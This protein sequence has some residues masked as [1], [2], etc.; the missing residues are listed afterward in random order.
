MQP[1]AG[2]ICGEEFD[3]TP[4]DDTKEEKAGRTAVGCWSPMKTFFVG[5]ATGGSGG[6]CCRVRVGGGG[7][8]KLV[9]GDCVGDCG[10]TE[11]LKGWL[12]WLMRGTLDAAVCFATPLGCQGKEM[13]QLHK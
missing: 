12:L 6:A 4:L 9:E 1:C 5:D 8:S 7:D 3:G 13:K 11:A 10:A 2:V